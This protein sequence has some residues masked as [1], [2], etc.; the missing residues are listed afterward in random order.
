M[1][2][3]KPLPD[4]TD[5]SPPKSAGAARSVDIF[6][7]VIDNFGDAGVCWR[8]ARQLA[9]E[10]A[11]SVRLWLDRPD[12]LALLLASPVPPGGGIT[13]E[14]VSI[15]HWNDAE[16]ATPA[17]IVIEA[18]ACDPPETYIERM[19]AAAKAP[20]WINLEY[21]SAEA[22]V[23]GSHL[24]PSRHPRLG[25]L[26]YFYFPGFTAATGG[27]LR[28]AGLEQARH[29][30]CAGAVSHEAFWR[31]CGVMPP[32]PGAL[33]VSLFCYENAALPSL[34]DAWA[35]STTP[36]Y[37]AVPA[38]RALPAIAAWA[39]VETLP[40]G[41]LIDRG[42]LRLVVLPFLR[43]TDYD[44]LL[45]AC[46][47]NFVRGEDSFVRAQWAARALVW[48]IY[49]QEEGAHLVK[50]EAFLN[51]YTDAWPAH[52][53]AAL[54]QFW[55]AWERQDGGPGGVA[56]LWPALYANLSSVNKHAAAWA[57]GLRGH[58]DLASRLLIFCEG[59]LE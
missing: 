40:P 26:K 2:A 24:M 15:A 19:A 43:Q 36:I 31:R 42:T 13:M 56:S 14:R 52:E 21:L 25:L 54:R 41:G 27:L 34:L 3:L 5:D 50:L 11:C 9:V 18:F 4:S 47:L 12:A 35:D 53:A 57:A 44:A 39:G 59:L 7:R 46:E 28:E 1:S 38:G 49:Q 23:E 20:A 10:H 45:W 8:L 17:E 6:C 16:V 37:C 51:L 33:T 29:P 30:F 22:W 32:A 58:G 48:H 55:L